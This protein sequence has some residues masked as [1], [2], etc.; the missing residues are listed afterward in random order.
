MGWRQGVAKS[1]AMYSELI[2]QTAKG[3]ISFPRPLLNSFI[4]LPMYH[5]F[6][7]F[8]LS[9]TCRSRGKE[10]SQSGLP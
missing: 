4:S 5:L 3:P 8:P 9:Y 10:K 2:I 1:T 7:N 6:P